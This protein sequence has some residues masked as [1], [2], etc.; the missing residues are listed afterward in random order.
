MRVLLAVAIAATAAAS[1]LK[2]QTPDTAAVRA[3]VERYLH[4]LKFNDTV[5]LHNAFTR[6]AKLYYAKPDGTLGEWTQASWYAGFAASAG[7]EEQGTLRIAALEVT[8]DIASVKVVEEYPRSRYID[9]LNL[10]KFGG[11]WWIVNKI[12]TSERR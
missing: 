8:R 3:V 9:Y 5:S 7:K 2:A 12:Y 6:D 10:V 1:P 11:R 4:G